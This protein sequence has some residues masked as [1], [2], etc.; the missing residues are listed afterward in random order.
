MTAAAFQPADED[1][2]WAMV[3]EAWAPLGEAANRARRDLAARSPVE[4]EDHAAYELLGRVED[5]HVEFLANL[6]AA[7]EPLTAA[8]LTALDAVVERKL[9]DLDRA[10]VHE[11]TDGSDDGFLYARGFIVSLG[12]DYYEAV[13]RE[14][15]LAVLEADC[16]EMGYFFAHLHHKRHGSF[17]ATGSGISR[18]SCSNRAGW[19][20]F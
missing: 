9:Y 19:P 8:E 11:V 18:E 5:V 3:E 15:R 14:P 1:R 4:G 17:P 16:Q 6:R 13:M 7:S 2:F 10:D 20:A 12:R